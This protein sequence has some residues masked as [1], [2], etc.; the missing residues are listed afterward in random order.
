MRAI[1]T[2]VDEEKY[3]EIC[4]RVKQYNF[5][6]VYEFV[7]AV[8]GMALL[9]MDR[10]DYRKEHPN[11][12]V[13]MDEIDEMFSPLENWEAPRYGERTKRGHKAWDYFGEQQDTQTELDFGDEEEQ[14]ICKDD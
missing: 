10:L 2:K 13:I 5:S 12:P 1:L 8:V 4:K 9:Q 6:S 14:D 7:H 11:E 3:I